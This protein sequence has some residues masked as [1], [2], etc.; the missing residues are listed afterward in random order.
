MT[1]AYT[2]TPSYATYSYKAINVSANKK[3]RGKGYRCTARLLHHKLDT[4]ELARRE[5]VRPSPGGSYLE[6]NRTC[7]GSE[8]QGVAGREKLRRCRGGPGSN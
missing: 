3:E 4:A 6:P 7:S 8:C 2:A 5:K 1:N